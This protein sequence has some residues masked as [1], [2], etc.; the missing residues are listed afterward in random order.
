MLG[1]KFY[2]K[3]DGNKDTSWKSVSKLPY[4]L[5][6]S[7]FLRSVYGFIS[8]AGA[9]LSIKLC[10]TSIAIS[11]M[12]TQVFVSSLIGYLLNDE[13]IS[14]REIMSIIGGFLGVLVLQDADKLFDLGR[15]RHSVE[16]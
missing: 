9:M 14:K 13:Y 2:A 6:K 12:M 7:L 15:R 3:L 16:E 5:K 11:I 1:A 4:N 10:P 8:I